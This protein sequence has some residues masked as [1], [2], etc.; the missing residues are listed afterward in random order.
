[1]RAPIPI[2]PEEPEERGLRLV[3]GRVETRKERLLEVGVF[4]FLIVPSMILGL[5]VVQQQ[6]GFTIIAL[7]TIFRDLALVAL[8]QFFLWRN[9]ESLNRIGWTLPGALTEIG[10]GLVLFIPAFVATSALNQLLQAAGL[11]GPTSPSP[12]FLS[13]S[14]AWQV[15]LAVVLVIVVAVAEETIFRGYLILRFENVLRSAVAAVLLSAMVF[16][17]GHG[18]EGEAGVVTVGVMGVIFALVYI[19]RR[20]LVAPITMH[21]LQDFLAVVLLPLIQ[22]LH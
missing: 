11:S 10:L 20:S 9:G 1:M 4:L 18:Y 21:F 19:W 22:T 14:G 6:L 3:R 16:S 5:F 15:A 17:I 13:P 12:S 8:I 7:S 2:Q